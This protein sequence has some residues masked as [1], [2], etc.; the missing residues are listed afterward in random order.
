MGA[1]VD[2]ARFTKGLKVKYTMF[3]EKDDTET[4]MVKG[5]LN[6]EFKHTKYVIELLWIW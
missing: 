5:T 1:K 3:R 4:K 2:K 6:P